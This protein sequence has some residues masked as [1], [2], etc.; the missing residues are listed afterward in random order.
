MNRQRALRDSLARPAL[1][2]LFPS[3]VLHARPGSEAEEPSISLR[4]GAALAAVGS[5][6]HC[7]LWE[8]S[9][10]LKYSQYKLVLQLRD[11]AASSIVIPTILMSDAEHQR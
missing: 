3:S 5:D 4:R 10:A 7:W 8:A 1:I 6:A 9:L 11:R 2:S